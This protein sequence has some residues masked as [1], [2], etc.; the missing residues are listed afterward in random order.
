M[1]SS[2][3]PVCMHFD[4]KHFPSPGNILQ[5]AAHRWRWMTP[6]SSV[7]RQLAPV[8]LNPEASFTNSILIMEI[9]STA[10]SETALP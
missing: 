9:S 7:N 10:R 3:V 1:F 2:R 4:T 5:Q 6:T 8:Q